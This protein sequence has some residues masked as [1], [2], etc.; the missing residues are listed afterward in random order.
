[1]NGHHL[2]EIDARYVVPGMFVATSDHTE[3]REVAA[4]IDCPP[5]GIY[6]VGCTHIYFVGTT[7]YTLTPYGRTL[8]T[9]DP[10]GIAA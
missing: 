9:L 7:V 5:G 4:V 2:Y 10:H 3:P 1:M 8:T 6:A